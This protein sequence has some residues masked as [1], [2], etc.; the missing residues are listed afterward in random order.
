MGGRADR[1]GRGGARSAHRLPQGH[2]A[3]GGGAGGG[4]GVRGL[5]YAPCLRG[6]PGRGV[7]RAPSGHALPGDCPAGRRDRVHRAGYARGHRGRPLR[8]RPA[9]ARVHA[10]ARRDDGGGQE[11]LRP[12]RGRR[13]AHA[14]PL[15]PPRRRR[16]TA[17]RLHLPRRARRAARVSGRPRG[18]PPPAHR[19]D[20]SPGSC[21]GPG[22]VL[23]RVRRRHRLHARRGPR[24]LRRRGPPRARAQ[25]PRRPAHRHGRGRAR[26]RGGRRERRSPRMRLARGHRSPAAGRHG[27]REPAPGHARARRGAPTRAGAHRRGRAGGRGDRLQPRQRPLAG[28]PPRRLA[29]LHP[30]AHD[31]ARGAEGPHHLRR[32]RPPTRRP[33]RQPPARLCRRPRGARRAERGG[34]AV[35]LSAR[36][37]LAHHHRRG[38]GVARAAGTQG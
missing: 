17:A 20:A 31:A 32:P 12:R 29:R 27:G 38:G 25:A 19:H 1:V 7:W 22:H 10:G 4:A 36:P 37:G 28:P 35:R 2:A 34:V 15:P 11:R 14:P 30:P 9:D 24:V 6:R 3:L 18:L 5:P 33:G 16:A 23:R 21:R 26:R 13:T 8:P